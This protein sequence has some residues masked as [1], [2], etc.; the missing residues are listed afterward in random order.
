MSNDILSVTHV[1]MTD[2][3]SYIDKTT[4][5]Q[6]RSIL[7]KAAK[8]AAGRNA[9]DI[10]AGAMNETKWLEQ[11]G[12]KVVSIDPHV[13]SATFSIP[14]EQYVFPIENY[15]LVSAL[16]VLPFIP[17][18]DTSQ[19]VI[20]IH[21]SLTHNGI[22]VGQFFGLN[23]DWEKECSLY[24]KDEIK[25]MFKEKF[26]FLLFE[27]REFDRPSVSGVM[28]HWHVFDIIARKK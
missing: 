3:K 21:K 18:E 14:I 8:L 25:A 28:K 24:T 1:A 15:D 19:V 4:G 23:D 10:G 17:K 26:N 11:N 22:F 20:N 5:A 7:V 12:Y 6:P 9:L 16:Y 27:E 13:E 2:W